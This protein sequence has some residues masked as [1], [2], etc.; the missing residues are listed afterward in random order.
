MSFAVSIRRKLESD[1]FEIEMIR[2][3]E[4]FQVRAEKDGKAFI[5]AAESLTAAYLDVVSLIRSK[6]D[7]APTP[8]SAP[9]HF[10]NVREVHGQHRTNGSALFKT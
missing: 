7:A 3:G 6:G 2:N 4:L 8:H 5:A 9:K 10:A 1:G